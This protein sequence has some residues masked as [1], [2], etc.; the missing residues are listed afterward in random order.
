MRNS[1]KPDD[2]EATHQEP[3]WRD[4]ANFIVA[5]DISDSPERKKWEQLWARQIAENRFEICC[6]PFFAYD[7]ALGDE[8]E[9]TEDYVI[10]KLVRPSGHY[11]FRAWFGNSPDADC[12]DKVVTSLLNLG[13]ELEWSSQNLLAIDA[14]T[15]DVAQAAAD[16]LSAFEQD[17]QIEYETGRTSEYPNI[18]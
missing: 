14:A 12:R 3:A 15:Q 11:T 5:A 16:Q 6:I 2:Y 1:Y 7:L 10:Q 9:T 4:R 13:C 8:V 17:H 18:A